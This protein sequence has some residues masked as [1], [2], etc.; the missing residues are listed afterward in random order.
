M[1]GLNIAMKN[2]GK[3]SE[4]LLKQFLWR[5]FYDYGNVSL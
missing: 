4:I 2:S 3:N 5:N 1:T